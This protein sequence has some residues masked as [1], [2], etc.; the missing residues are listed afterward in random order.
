VQFRHELLSELPE[1]TK[2][3]H[4]LP[5]DANGPTIPYSLDNTSVNAWDPQS[6]NGYIVRIIL[7]GLFGGCLGGPGQL[8]YDELSTLGKSSGSAGS[9]TLP[10]NNES[11]NYDDFV[12]K[13]IVGGTPRNSKMKAEADG[14]KPISNGLVVDHIACGE[15]CELIWKQMM[16]MQTIMKWNSIGALGVYESSE[17]K[18]PKGIIS[19]PGFDLK[20]VTRPVLKMLA[21]VSP[22][23]TLNLIENN[24]VLTKYRLHCPPRIYKFPQLSCKNESCLSHPSQKQREVTAY[25]SRWSTSE[26]SL[27]EN[28]VGVSPVSKR[29]RKENAQE[30]IR[31]RKALASAKFCCKYCDKVHSFKEIWATQ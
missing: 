25:F 7:L 8:G 26:S 9:L 22:G 4:P 17:T 14:I 6:R 21:A 23:C 15:D 13:L 31:R 29:P 3:F 30:K 19:L 10:L 1:N 24:V 16:L 27:S 2:F 5:R 28:L 12:E 20:D 11:A 18:M